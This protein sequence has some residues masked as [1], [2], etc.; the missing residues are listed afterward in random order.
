[1]T[2][3]TVNETWLQRNLIPTCIVVVAVIILVVLGAIP[4][5]KEIIPPAEVV[6]VNVVTLAVSALPEMADGFDLPGVVEPFQVV[7][8]AAEVASHVDEVV[9]QEG[10]AVVAGA[11]ILR[12][13]SDLLKTEYDRAVAQAKYDKADYSRLEELSRKGAVSGSEREAAEVRMQ[14][15]QAAAEEIRTR[16]DRAV[17]RAPITG[18]LNRLPVEVGEY[19][20]AGMTVAQIVQIDKVKVAVEAPEKDVQYLSVAD[21]AVVVASVKGEERQFDGG[22]TYI[23]QLADPGTRTSR[24]EI[25]VPNQDHLLRSGQIVRV[26]LTRRILRDVIMI[27]LQSVIPLENGK[28]VFVVSEGK[29]R[30]RDVELGIIRG[31]RIQVT[32]GL[33]AGDLLIVSGHRFVGPD[34]PV[35]VVTPNGAA[36]EGG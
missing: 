14:V 18:I 22:V 27:P 4:R 13:D 33:V 29:A 12:L 19:V 11:T 6:T 28:A 16:L 31:D 32:R 21:K 9:G 36:Q 2:E 10:A 35:N 15:S 34:Q 8:I 5:K 17:I 1:M 20:N 30:Q 26:R 23:S 7:D 3:P 24:V 25:T